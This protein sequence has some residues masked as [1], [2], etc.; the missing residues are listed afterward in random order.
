MKRILILSLIAT[1]LG[2]AAHHKDLNTDRGT[3]DEGEYLTKNG[4]YE[5]GRKQY[6]RIKTDFPQSPLQVEADFKI[7]D[8]FYEEES[9]QTAASSFQEFLKTYPGRPEAS[10]AL[11]KLGMSYAKQMPSSSQRDTRPSA[12]VIDTFTRLIMDYPN[13]HHAAEAQ[14]WIEKARNQLAEKVFQIGSFY[15]RRKEYD[16]AAR[17]F[18]ELVDQYANHPLAEEAFAREIQCLRLSG[19]ADKSDRLIVK[20]EEKFPKSKFRSMIGK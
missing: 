13:S 18:G 7:A 5:E 14:T 2:C 15:E 19:Q 12:K 1:A 10:E 6:F 9:Y 17:R 3:L 20:F 4:F 16:S 11:Y 8:S